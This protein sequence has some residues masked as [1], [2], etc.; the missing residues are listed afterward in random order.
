MGQLPDVLF[1]SK[2][3]SIGD[4]MAGIAATYEQENRGRASLRRL[5]PVVERY[6]YFDHA[7]V[8]P[9]TQPA[10]EAIQTWVEQSRCH[11]DVHW[12]EWSA[13]AGRLRSSAAQLIHAKTSEIALI[14]NTTFGI[15]VVAHG[16]RWNTQSTRKDSVVVLENEFS[17]NLLPWLALE[18]RG[19]EVRK[20][21][22]DPSGVVSIDAIR[23]AIDSTTRLVAVS[24]VGYFSGFRMD[25]AKLCEMVHSA[26]A[27]L[28][29]DAIQGLGVFSLNSQE[30]PIDY[31]AADGH[32]WMLGPEG[33][34]FLFVRQSKLEGLEPLMQGWGSLQMAHDFG[35]SQ[36]VLKDDA[37]RYEGGSAN[38][39]G[40]IGLSE[41]LRVLL[42]LGC[43]QKSNPIA[44]AVLEN[45]AKIEEG[46]LSAG[47]SVFRARSSD[48]LD[49]EWSDLSGIITFNVPGMKP[50]DV[51]KK[52]L[53]EQIVVSVRHGRLRV[54]T[55]AYN[56]QSD[57]DRL[58]DTIR[59]LNP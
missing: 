38:H 40:Q 51:R 52:L 23:R 31:L 24:W 17:S 44:T 59:S 19:V 49:G 25:L 34:G 14:P 30:I 28:F 37:S 16:Y 9:M 3:L 39:V 20:V 1:L 48:R 35:N 47:A 5:M 32:K 13:A 54:A 22:V 43:N 18:R 26:G 45:A 15:N 4:R 46:L 10:A 8:G 6:A 53:D 41:S 11:G 57:I 42:E 12:P 56:D 36:M 58:V 55:H 27:E 50:M 21:P 2:N 33:A 29:V 7:A